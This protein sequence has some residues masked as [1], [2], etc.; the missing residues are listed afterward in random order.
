MT[1]TR[2]SGWAAALLGVLLLWFQGSGMATYMA[3]GAGLSDAFTIE[4]G[5]IIGSALLVL[6]AGLLCATQSAKP[7]PVA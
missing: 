7:R 6:I 3:R 5:L 2:L 1:I 4:S